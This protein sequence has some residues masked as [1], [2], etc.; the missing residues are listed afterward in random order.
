MQNY[1]DGN[2]PITC[3]WA[4][5]IARGSAGGT[6]YGMRVGTPILASF[7]GTLINR[8][9]GQY[10][11]SGNVAILTRNDGLAFY[12]LHLSQF[13]TPGPVSQGNTIG[14][15][16]GAVGA[17][18]SG[19]STGPHLHINA[20]VGNTIHDVHDFYTTTTGTGTGTPITPIP[21]TATTEQDEPTMYLVRRVADGDP[22]LN[23]MT[24]AIG[25]GFFQ[26]LGSGDLAGIARDLKINPANIID[27]SP[28]GSDGLPAIEFMR[29]ISLFHIPNGNV[30]PG[31]T[32]QS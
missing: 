24:C 15:S 19:E 23:G 1:L 16:G 18:G 26:H 7:D 4:C 31:G 6:D 30:K 22:V 32:Y 11:A 3:D 27:G 10:P 21:P 20:Y 5:H 28:T 8:P 2:Y 14:Y 13:V 29:L 17:P 12:H 9:P 25:P